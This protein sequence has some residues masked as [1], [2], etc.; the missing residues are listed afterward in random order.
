MSA[1]HLLDC[2]LVSGGGIEPPTNGLNLR[3][4]T[5]ELPALLSLAEESNLSHAAAFLAEHTERA[6]ATTTS[7]RQK[8]YASDGTFVA[9]PLSRGEH[10]AFTYNVPSNLQTVL[11]PVLLSSREL[12][13]SKPR[14]ALIDERNYNEDMLQ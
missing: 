7:C 1:S 12:D 8:S 4:S 9:L 6:Q 3:C 5:G 11:S 14:M 2:L 13:I 10:S